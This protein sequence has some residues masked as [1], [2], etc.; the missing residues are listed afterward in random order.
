MTVEEIKQNT[1]L[2]DVL[3]ERGIRVN[4]GMASC[5]FHG[6]DRHPSM[7]VYKDGYRCFTC[8]DYGDVIQFVMK[9]DGVDFKTAFTS[10]GGT[11]AKIS[12]KQ[13]KMAEIKRQ[14]ARRQRERKEKSDRGFKFQLSR[15]ITTCSYVIELYEPFS[16]EW[17]DAMN[18]KQE[19]LQIWDEKFNNGEEVNEVRVYR[20]CKQ[21]NERFNSL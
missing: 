6:D 7:R 16:D 1:N 21:F 3:S 15:A 20:K 17:C 5:P 10:L 8:G 9:Y 13:R 4:R 19:L 11:Y 18:M 14:D 2:C 12:D